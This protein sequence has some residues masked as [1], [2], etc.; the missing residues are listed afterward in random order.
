MSKK[1]KTKNFLKFLL[2]FSFAFLGVFSG[3]YAAANNNDFNNHWAKY[4]IDDWV[5]KNIITLDEGK[6]RPN[7]PITRG[8]FVN[9][10]NSAFHLKKVSDS[11]FPDVDR[12]HKYYKDTLIAKGFGY[13][14][15]YQ[16]GSFRP[17]Q[18]IT[19]QEAAVILCNV[20]SPQQGYLGSLNSFKDYQE[21]KEWSRQ[22]FASLLS[23]GYIH[24]YQDGTLKPSAHMTRAEALV[25]IYNIM[26]DLK[27]PLFSSDASLKKIEIDFGLKEYKP[28]ILLNE[29]PNLTLKQLFSEN[30]RNLRRKMTDIEL[31][32]PE[33]LF[34]VIPKDVELPKI[35]LAEQNEPGANVE[36]SQ[37]S[38]ENNNTGEILVTAPT[39]DQKT[40]R[41]VFEWGDY[42]SKELK[43]FEKPRK[44]KLPF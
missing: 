35:S 17:D 31:P 24:G 23:K 29:P 44:V 9:F 36:I 12:D 13:T 4:A 19:R 32:Y 8:E 14:K 6:F 40:Y 11:P 22:P 41:I 1:Y 10:I 30:R 15:G 37:P 27:E 39:G 34:I 25:I 21:I 3:I 20:L 16:D 33:Q 28:L 2:I 42:T 18:N 7:D 26:E 38:E 43:D 5:N